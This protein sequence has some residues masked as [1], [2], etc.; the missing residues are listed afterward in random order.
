MEN[1]DQQTDSWKND[2]SE[3]GCLKPGSKKLWKFVHHDDFEYKTTVLKG[4]YFNGKWL[5]I[6][7]GIIKVKGS[8][9]KNRGYAWDGCTPN[10]N[11]SQTSYCKPK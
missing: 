2:P 10:L 6:Y 8:R 5:F 1:G 9:D 4:R 11:N 3:G 7:D